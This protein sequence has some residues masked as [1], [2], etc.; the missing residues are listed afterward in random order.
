MPWPD[1]VTIIVECPSCCGDK[2]FTLECSTRGGQVELCGWDEFGEPS[3]PPRYYLDKNLAGSVVICNYNSP[4]GKGPCEPDDCASPLGA[5]AL[6]SFTG[7]TSCGGASIQGNAIKATVTGVGPTPG[8]PGSVRIFL[9]VDDTHI[10]DSVGT[11]LIYL[12]SSLVVSSISSGKSEVSRDFVSGTIVTMTPG[13][14]NSCVSGGT[15]DTTGP[16]V[17]TACIPLSDSIRY[18]YSGSA[19]YDPAISCDELAT[20]TR[21]RF[22]I[23]EAA[24]CEPS[25]SGGLEQVTTTAFEPALTFFVETAPISGPSYREQ[26]S[27]GTCVGDKRATFCDR[28]ENLN[29]EDTEEDGIARLLANPTTGTWSDY[30]TV[31]DGSGDT[32]K[33]PEC[34]RA[35]YEVRLGRIF[36]Y[37]EAAFRARVVGLL[38]GTTVDINIA[39]RRRPYGDGEYSLFQVLTFGATADAGGIAQIE[40]DV[41]N[42]V[43][44]ETYASSCTF[45]I[46]TL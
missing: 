35:R 29:G 25:M 45:Q 32:C 12:N 18:V 21:R 42:A 19:K 9:S 7:P 5:M 40:G 43:G 36:Q 15:R 20:D 46:I 44:F 17:F 8:T 3:D 41:P 39:I 10:V 30:K 16:V 31:Y 13:V 38:E 23:D 37:N 1:P 11:G 33:N 4:P 27:T 14:D 26:Q 2:C 22:T 6:E 34:C 24:G 28:N